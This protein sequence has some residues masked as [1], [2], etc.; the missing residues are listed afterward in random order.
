MAAMQITVVNGS[1]RKQGTSTT[2]VRQLLERLTPEGKA[3]Q[4]HDLN[5]LVIRGCQEC[6]A[7]RNQKTDTCAVRDE[8]SPVLEAGKTTDVLILSS[9]VFYADVSAQLKCF[10]DRTWSYYGRTGVS[11]LHLPRNRTLVFVLSY[12]YTE[13]NVYDP[14]FEK[15]RR[16]F[17][18]FGFSRCHFVKAYGSQFHSPEIVNGPEVSRQVAAIACELNGSQ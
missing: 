12:G 3:I 8:L 16:Y 6:F 13:P 1:P 10:I 4:Q 18:M 7:C 15:Y 2:V 17:E 11:A 14:L 5:R 9:P